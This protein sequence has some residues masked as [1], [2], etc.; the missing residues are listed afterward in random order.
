M[1]CDGRIGQ[2]K[3]CLQHADRRKRCPMLA[4]NSQL[5]VP[6]FIWAF[7]EQLNVDLPYR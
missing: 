5:Q 7:Q 2:L 6:D 4:A 1:S 3:A